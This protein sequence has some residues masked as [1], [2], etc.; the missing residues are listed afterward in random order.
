MDTRKIKRVS[1]LRRLIISISVVCV[2][3]SAT[4]VGVSLYGGGRNGKAAYAATPAWALSGDGTSANPWLINTAAGLYAFAAAVNGGNDMLHTFIRLTAD[5]DLSAYGSN[6]NGGIGWSLIGGRSTTINLLT[7]NPSSFRGTFDGGGFTV[8]NLYINITPFYADFLGYLHNNTIYAGLFGYVGSNGAIKNLGVSGVTTIAPYITGLQKGYAGGIAGYNAGSITGSY[9]N[10]TVTATSSYSLYAGG[11]AGYNAGSITSSYNTAS[12]TA[13]GSSASGSCWAGGI[14]G[15]NAGSITSGY[16]T[17]SAA[18][19]GIIL[20]SDGGIA[21]RNT[22]SITGSYS[23]ASNGIYGNYTADSIT[24]NSYSTGAG[25]TTPQMTA[26]NTLQSGG[27]MSGLDTAAFSKR[28]NDT[29]NGV[30]YYPELTVFKNSANAAVAG[31]SRISVA[32]GATSPYNKPV[33]KITYDYGGATGNNAVS[34]DLAEAGHAYKLVVPTKMTYT[35]E[36][37][38][39]N[40]LLCTDSA[41]AGIAAFSYAADI[42]VSARWT[43]N[44][45]TVSYY[46]NGSTS[47]SMNSSTHIYS[48]SADQLLSPNGYSKN[49]WVFNGWNTQAGGGGPAYADRASIRTL[50]A[51]S[52]GTLSLYAQWTQN[53][54]KITY[55]GN[56]DRVTG[57]TPSTTHT[58]D[59]DQRI[60]A[61][62]YLRTGY[63]FDGWRTLPSAGKQYAAGDSIRALT[64]AGGGT[65][66]LYAQWTAHTYKVVY[67]VNGNNFAGSMDISRHTYDLEAP[68][69][70]NN[71]MR[72]GYAFEGWA[73]AEDDRVKYTDCQTVSNLTAIN[74]AIVHLFAKWREYE[75]VVTYYGNGESG[76]S[77]HSSIHTY[78]GNNTLSKNGYLKTGYAFTGWN[79]QADGNGTPY[80]A[81]ANIRDSAAVSDGTLSL[82]A[83]WTAYRYTVTYNANGGTG[84]AMA[85]S[86]HAYDADERL[87]AN[88]YLKT[89]YAFTGWSTLENGTGTSYSAGDSIRALTAVGGGTLSLYAKWE[90]NAY[91]VRYDKNGNDVTGTTEDSLFTYGASAPLRKNGYS[92]TG[93]TFKYWSERSDGSGKQYGDGETVINLISSGN[94]VTLYAQWGTNVYKVSYDGNGNTGGSTEASTHI[95]YSDWLL[96]PNGYTRTGYTFADWNTEADGNGDAYADEES[97]RDLIAAG[98]GGLSLYARWELIRYTITYNGLEGAA[99]GNLGEYTIESVAITLAALSREGY[100]FGGWYSDADF[101]GEAVTSIAAG[102]TGNKVFWAKWT[103]VADGGDGGDGGDDERKPVP[104]TIPIAVTTGGLGLFFAVR[105]I[106]SAGNKKRK[107]AALAQ[108]RSMMPI[109]LAPGVNYYKVDAQSD[110]SRMSKNR[111]PK[112]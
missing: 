65:L 44:K 47:G 31:A 64:E 79:T 76:G 27:A 54:Y 90:A 50:L 91:T 37:W 66:S 8:S 105:A 7:S 13:N 38:L 29:A 42:T 99:N 41:G 39:V 96:A 71:Y 94:E 77:M 81:E 60:A 43:L 59:G 80:A 21:G 93:Y 10:V 30:L 24:T 112:A 1:K 86:T 74:D 45:Y 88:G 73:L 109:S 72:L 85:N 23:T 40:G 15:Y 83:R 58:Y 67:N 33:Y 49:G 52:S 17:G 32:A 34:F 69:T 100:T 110:K 92:K 28:P 19:K 63:T 51:V 35:F 95:Y 101:G 20:R 61:N 75:Y 104:L 68:L 22:G 12:V 11:I 103:A 89:G 48:A 98:S 25:L 62:G 4:L 36:G 5:I 3:A 26:D 106:V 107:A 18:V 14:A 56:G 55:Y 102:S 9:N 78:Y 2:L 46:G 84:T 111:R 108:A 70:K 87:S 82:Y 6:V 97:I 53:T 57:A 16:N